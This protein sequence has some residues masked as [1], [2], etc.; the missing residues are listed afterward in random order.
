MFSAAASDFG[1][2]L[3]PD[4]NLITKRKARYCGFFL[5]MMA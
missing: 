3:K 4:Y 1:N 2:G 5:L